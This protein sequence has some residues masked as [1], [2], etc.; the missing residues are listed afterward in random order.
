MTAPAV[1]PLIPPLR[2]NQFLIDLIAEISGKNRDEVTHRFNE[3]H[4]DLGGNVRRALADA[5]IEPYQWSAALEKFYADTDAFLYETLVYNRSPFKNDM[6]SWIGDYLTQ[7]SPRPLRVLSFGDGL[8]IDAYYLAQLGHDVT[9]F[10]VSQ[11]C[12]TF[13]QRIFARGNLDVTMLTAPEQLP[14][15]SFDAIVCLDVLEH[16]PGPFGLVGWL[17]TILRPGG[18]LVVHAPFHYVDPAVQTH[19]RK[20]QRYSGDRK[21]LYEP[22]GLHVVAGRLFWNPL[23]LMKY[24]PGEMPLERP[25]WQ[26]YLGSALLKTGR[27]WSKP[28][29]IVGK[30]LLNKKQL[31][32]MVEKEQPYSESSVEATTVA[33]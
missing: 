27:I 23:V 20:N 11:P 4:R 15:E 9:Y 5:A 25:P 10:D 29:A 16:V 7:R 21:S 14:L 1:D 28:H 31:I 3:E 30:M 19:L 22:H 18:E 8:G 12:V 17:S 2:D 13:A 24:A 32:A 33:R 26:V 6:R